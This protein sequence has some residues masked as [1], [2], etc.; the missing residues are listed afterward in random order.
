M[1]SYM[2]ENVI[3]AGKTR[4][5]PPC[6]REAEGVGIKGLPASVFGAATVERPSRTAI[7]LHASWHQRV[8]EIAGDKPASGSFAGMAR[9]F[10]SQMET[11]GVP[12]MQ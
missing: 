3:Y 7:R 4:Q 11:L 1:F 6:C 9:A 2:Y 12:Q 10:C 5:S 8:D